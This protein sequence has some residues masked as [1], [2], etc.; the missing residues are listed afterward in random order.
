VIA[1]YAATLLVGAAS[2]LLPVAPA[3]PY[4]IA[5]AAATGDA[6]WILGTAAGA[7]QAAGKLLVFLAARGTLRSARVRRRL[8]AAALRNRLRR[9]ARA[10]APPGRAGG[11]AAAAL[12]RLDRPRQAA[13]VVFTSA[14]TGLPPLL[15]TTVYA[16][17]TPMSAA[18]FASTC[19][20]GRVIRFSL[21][22]SAPGLLGV[23][24]L[25]PHL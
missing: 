6:A 14:V 1:Q 13:A 23:L 2:A 3:E 16:A 20:A 10:P 18:V 9:P 15:V 7:G 8:A 17:R 4:V 21:V 12:A 24:H 22:A 25:H 5:V 19:L 11:R